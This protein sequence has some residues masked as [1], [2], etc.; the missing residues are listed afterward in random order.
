[1]A[2]A[3]GPTSLPQRNPGAYLGAVMGTLAQA[4]RDKV[5][6]ITSPKISSFGLWAEQLLAESTGKEGR[7]L[8]PIAQEPL[9]QPLAYG[10]DRLFIYLR[11]TGDSNVV[12][13]RHVKALE[14]NGQPVV[15]LMLRDRYDLAAEFFRWEFATAVAGRFLGI[16]PFDQ[17]NVQ[18]SKDNTSRILKETQSHGR[19]PSVSTNDTLTD[20]LAKAGPGRY[21]A[22][23]AYMK[24]SAQADAAI[25]ALR[26]SLLAKYRLATTAGY[27]PR[28]LHSTGQ[29]HKGGASTGLFLELVETMKPDV[30]IPN[31]RYTF[32]ILAKAQAVGDVLS[33]Q[34]H[35]RPVLQISLGRQALSTIRGLGRVSTRGDKPPVRRRPS[36]ARKTAASHRRPRK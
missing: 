21:L 16:H 8:I 19:L 11:L 28:Y 1:M 4:G 10:D 25:A 18:E 7:G 36:A 13:D 34:A 23:L 24:P 22:I 12:T 29:L 32:G 20:L 31:A 3:C 5:T 6:L 17:P 30:P 9:A 26:K 33:L 27:G 14:R 2:Q 15:T 35:N